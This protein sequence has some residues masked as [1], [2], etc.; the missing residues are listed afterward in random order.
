VGALQLADAGSISIGPMWLIRA[1][2]FNFGISGLHQFG[3]SIPGTGSQYVWS[4]KAGKLF[5]QICRELAQLEQEGYGRSPGSLAVALRAFMATYDRWP[6][7]PDS[8][9]L[10]AVTSA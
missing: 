2:R 3:V 7:G 5:P 9:L 1:A 10:D 4:G 8:Q 6:P